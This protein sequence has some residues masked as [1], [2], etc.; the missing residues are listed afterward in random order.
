MTKRV[1]YTAICKEWKLIN[2]LFF[3]H[4]VF[5]RFE[6]LMP[7]FPQLFGMSFM[8]IQIVYKLNPTPFALR[9]LLWWGFYCGRRGQESRIQGYW[10]GE[11]FFVRKGEWGV[12]NAVVAVEES[13]V[14]DVK[15]GTVLIISS[16]RVLVFN[17]SLKA[18]YLFCNWKYLLA[19]SSSRRSFRESKSA[20][21]PCIS[22]IAG[23]SGTGERL[24]INR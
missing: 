1:K 10:R 11:A 15:S 24:L 20:M 2:S 18:R 22:C 14:F 16:G 17:C 23:R 5:L 21:L 12:E 13:C 3:A 4:G 6:F 8:I 9:A 7:T 19:F